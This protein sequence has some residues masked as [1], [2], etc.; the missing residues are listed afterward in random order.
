MAKATTYRYGEFLILVGDGGSPENFLAP[1]GA[2]SQGFNRT[3]NMND[4]N[5]PDCADPDLPSWLER[6]VVSNSAEFPFSG[7]VAAESINMWDN[8]YESGDSKN[9]RIE[10]G[11]NVWQ[12]AAKLANF[13]I[14][15]ERG[16][17]VS[18]TASVVSDGPFVSVSS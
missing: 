17:R 6:D 1:C 18:F 15:G 14:T 2:T 5:V 7:V 12:G 16:G 4:T 11:A 9:T 10:L 13:N 8:W 3:A